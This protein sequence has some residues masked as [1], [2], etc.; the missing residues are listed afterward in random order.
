MLI[1]V[2][3]DSTVDVSTLFAC[4]ISVGFVWLIENIMF[5]FTDS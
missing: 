3:P 1:Y 5:K 2:T 4:C